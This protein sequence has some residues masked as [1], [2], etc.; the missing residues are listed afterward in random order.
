M[1]E[2][3]IQNEYQEKIKNL[4]ELLS[5]LKIG[6]EQKANIALVIM[7]L[8]PA[9][10]LYLYKNNDPEDLVCETLTNCG[11]EVRKK[12]T[13]EK[14]LKFAIAKDPNIAEQLLKINGNK[15]HEL[16]GRLMGYPNTAI[17]AFL[18]KEDLLDQATENRL[19][20]NND[21]I[22]MGYFKLSKNHYQE[23]LELMETWNQAIKEHA[24]SIY[25]SLKKALDNKQ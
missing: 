18:N 14:C 20:Q 13:T 12:E 23:E 19:L 21:E 10:E 15:D 24:P 2:Q 7:E 22:Y 3:P 8:K 4:I 5:A 6:P 17:Q 25:Q 1:K 16:Y 11:L 9:T